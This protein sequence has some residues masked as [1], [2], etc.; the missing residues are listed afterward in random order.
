MAPCRTRASGSASSGSSSTC[1]G[2]PTSATPFRTRAC[3]AARN[4]ERRSSVSTELPRI[5]NLVDGRL[6]P[7]S[8]GRWLDVIE[9]ATGQVF[10]LAPDGDAADVDA[11]VDAARRAAPAWA[12]APASERSRH[13]LRLASLIEE[14]LDAFAEC[15]SRDAGKPLQNARS[16]DIPRAISNL[17][18]FAAAATQFAS[19]AH[20]ME[21]AAVN[22]TL[23]QPLGVV[24]CISPWNLPLYLLTWKFA[25]A[26]AAGN[27]VV[28][29]PSEVTPATAGMLAELAVDAGFPPGV[30]N[31]VHGRGPSVG[32]AIVDHPDVRA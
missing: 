28:A 5:P 2:S 22:Y 11:A 9:P 16:V 3:R 24:G 23:R 29:K 32:Q 8:S 15:E 10:A 18:F 27:T 1:A 17:R 4:S 14:R 19:E 21:D 7:P 12:S 26:L 6:V 31:L 13:L 25:P 20:A 30:L